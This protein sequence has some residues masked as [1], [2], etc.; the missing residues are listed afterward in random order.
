MFE[1]N[2]Y[3]LGNEGYTGVKQSVWESLAT[4]HQSNQGQMGSR[5]VSRGLVLNAQLC[6]NCTVCHGE[7]QARAT[8]KQS[9]EEA[10]T[11][12]L[13]ACPKQVDL[14]DEVVDD[15]QLKQHHQEVGFEH[16]ARDQRPQFGQLL[17]H[18]CARPEGK[19]IKD[20]CELCH[21]RQR[22]NGHTQVPTERSLL[23][24]FNQVDLLR[25]L[26][27]LSMR[28]SEGTFVG[29]ECISNLFECEPNTIWQDCKCF[30]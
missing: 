10:Q 15:K 1:R 28:V 2:S 24:E 25:F 12:E 22:D 4:P 17:V 27:L 26:W 19:E 29:T 13:S 6:Q 7:Q 18:Y 9:L 23:R 30:R 14:I 21:H 3:V 20:A 16:L 11:E 8:G 5:A